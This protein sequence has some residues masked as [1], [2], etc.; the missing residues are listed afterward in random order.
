MINCLLIVSRFAE[1]HASKNRTCCIPAL[2]SCR[3]Y[4]SSRSN[5]SY[6]GDEASS[7]RNIYDSIGDLRSWCA[8]S[9]RRSAGRVTS[10]RVCQADFA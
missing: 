1:N 4:C 10:T 3:K 2:Q 7:D 6:S 5:K 9:H 8:A